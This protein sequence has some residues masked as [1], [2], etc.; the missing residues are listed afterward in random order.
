MKF[1]R[2]TCF[3]F[4]VFIFYS[5]QSYCQ[6][7][8]HIDWDTLINHSWVDSVFNSMSEEERLGQLF[9][10]DAY[11]DR[12][13]SY[14][15][16]LIKSVTSNHIGGI[17]FLQGSPVRQATLANEIQESAK[18]PL[19]MAIDGEWGLAMKMDS[20][21]KFPYHMTM[22]AI[23]D[24]DLI[25][26]TGTSIARQCRRLGIHIN[27]APV[28]DINNNPLNPVINFRSFGES[29]ENVANKSWQLAKGMQDLR[30]LPV[31]KHFPGH[32]DT[33]VDSHIGLPV[34]SHDL[35]RLDSLELYPF[36][37]CI[38]QGVGGIMVAHMNVPSL[39]ASQT[40]TSLSPNVIHGL[41]KDSLDFHGI[42]FSDALNMKGVSDRYAPGELEV[43]ALLAGND[44]LLI[45][46]DV[47][48]AVQK[49]HRAVEDGTL[50]PA[51]IETR[52]KK[53]LALKLWA[54]MDKYKPVE[55]D[56]LWSDI[57]LPHDDMINEKL[58][59]SSITLLENKNVI[60]IQGLDTL[61]I[62]ALSIGKRN[63]TVF[64]KT[65]SMYTKVTSLNISK[66][67]SDADFNRLYRKLEDFDLVITGVHSVGLFPGKNYNMPVEATD[68]LGELSASGKAVTAVFGS[69]YLLGSIENV[70]N[71][72]GLIVAYQET[73]F[74]QR[75]AAEAIFG[76]IPVRGKLPVSIQN[77][78]PVG[79]GIEISKAIRLNYTFPEDLGINTGSLYRID[80]LAELAIRILIPC[81]FL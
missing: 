58:A 30:I 68:F 3:L 81:E 8:S 25:Y 48:M 31:A 45:P 50:D 39:D 54:G 2:S 28:A 65:L 46:T 43:Q 63:E 72:K 80:S 75:A 7:K 17:I 49:I 74:T 53:V 40:P 73:G 14:T 77:I 78:Y 56:D 35:K 16:Q 9:M 55:T 69:P 21:I 19:L 71:S 29:R 10:V 47:S 20:T 34:I 60:P 36:K 66:N 33:D 18:V 1:S 5:G 61:N 51:S 11:S 26:L 41:L 24:Q 13:D 15:D 22:G 52:V 4:S 42:V 59:E 67:A 70:Q 38:D 12:S 27:F 37:H 23:E 64:Q 6:P 62:A 32:G 44:I 57:H 76:G 79:S